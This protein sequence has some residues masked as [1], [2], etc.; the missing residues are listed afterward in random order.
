[1]PVVFLIFSKPLASAKKSFVL[2]IKNS[3]FPS[4]ICSK[5]Q[6]FVQPKYPI[7]TPHIHLL[8][9]ALIS[10]GW[11]LFVSGYPCYFEQQGIYRFKMDIKPN[12]L[13]IEDSKSVNKLIHEHQTNNALI[14]EF[15]NPSSS[16]SL[17]LKLDF[18]EP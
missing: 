14:N 18:F 10:L 7:S 16:F 8:V 15:T 17:R 2:N 11:S 12:F 3:L 9:V 4:F 5:P 13:S 6:S 1:M